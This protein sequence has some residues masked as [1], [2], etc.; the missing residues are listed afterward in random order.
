MSNIVKTAESGP[1]WPVISVI[2]VGESTGECG[3]EHLFSAPFSTRFIDRLSSQLLVIIIINLIWALIEFGMLVNVLAGSAAV[4]AVLVDRWTLGR[5]HV[6]WCHLFSFPLS[7]HLIG[8]SSLRSWSVWLTSPWIQ[9][10]QSFWHLCAVFLLVS[11]MSASNFPSALIFFFP[12]LA[13]SSAQLEDLSFLNNQ[14]AAGHRGSVRKHNTAG[15]PSD[16]IKGI[17]EAKCGC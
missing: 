4:S 9:S 1:G 17:S 8:S 11:F 7:S 16:D 10:P 12:F 2:S 5:G 13:T 14:R 6:A 3:S 15:R